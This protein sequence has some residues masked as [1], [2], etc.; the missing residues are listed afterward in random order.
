MKY[1]SGSYAVFT[2]RC[3]SASL[4]TAAKVMDVIAR[5]ADCTGQAADAVSANTQVTLEDAPKLLNIPKSE[6]PDIWIRLSR[7]WPKILVKHR[8]RCGSS[9]TTFVWS[10]PCWLIVG[11]SKKLSWDSDGRSTE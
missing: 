6:C 7:Q 9:C 11:N 10:L 2:E 3:S 5:I 8:R 4:M 1:D